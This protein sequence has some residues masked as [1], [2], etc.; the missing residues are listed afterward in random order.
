MSEAIK[1][2][3]LCI[4]GD[5]GVGKTTLTNRFMTGVFK[6][7]Y[8]LTIGMDFHVK[9]IEIDGLLISLQI[10]DF[11][12][13]EK[14][15]FLLPSAIIGAHGALFLYDMSRFL[16]YK[17]L[18]NWISVFNDASETQ[19]QEIPAILIGAKLDLQEKR[20]VPPEEGEIFATENNFLDYLE[21]S[22]KTG[23]NVELVFE[24]IGRIMLEKSGLIEKSV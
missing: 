3:K 5:G 20:A 22:S 4:F 17:N 10:W 12:G 21:C 2:F 8:K 19:G 18:R 23:E 6:D 24:K 15:R 16:T 9:K 14:F 1:R 11:A 7:H 13:E